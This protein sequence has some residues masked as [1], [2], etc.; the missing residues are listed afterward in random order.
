MKTIRVR[1]LRLTS[2]LLTC[3]HRCLLSLPTHPYLHPYITDAKE[4][5][6]I[7]TNIKQ[8]MVSVRISITHLSKQ[9]ERSMME[10]ELFQRTI[11]AGSWMR[12]QEAGMDR[13]C[14]VRGGRVR[15]RKRQH[16]DWIL[17]PDVLPR[18][19]SFPSQNTTEYWFQWAFPVSI[20][21][22]SFKIRIKRNGWSERNK[23]DPIALCNT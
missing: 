4:K 12:R 23:L 8:K 2:G 16:A 22:W 9:G 13:A 6:T 21:E 3:T 15:G 5:A 11:R 1:H 20:Q 17:F 10:P 18:M 7:L 14:T 19:C